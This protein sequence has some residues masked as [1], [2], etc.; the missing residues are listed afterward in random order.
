MFESEIAAETLIVKENVGGFLGRVCRNLFGNVI[1]Q[2]D[3]I[4][5]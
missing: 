3:E 1:V 4:T 2:T 5:A